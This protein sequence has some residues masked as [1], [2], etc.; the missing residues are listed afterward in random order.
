MNT[1]LKLY[2]SLAKVRVDMPCVTKGESANIG[3]YSY[4]YSSLDKIQKLLHPILMKHGVHYVQ[5]VN[6]DGLKAGLIMKVVCLETGEFEEF[7]MSVELGTKQVKYTDHNNREVFE[8]TGDAYDP[9]KHGSVH[10]YLRRY[11]IV[12]FFGI[13]IEGEDNDAGDVASGNKSSYKSD[14]KEYDPQKHTRVKVGYIETNKFMPK[15]KEFESNGGGYD[16][17]KKIWFIPRKK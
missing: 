11:S 2:Q 16:F 12:C 7:S 10:T 6:S 1:K 17:D 4:S 14:K 8:V 5:I 13:V 9:Q 15:V 3:K